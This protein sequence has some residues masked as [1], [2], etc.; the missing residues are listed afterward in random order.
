MRN[1]SKVRIVYP[2][3]VELDTEVEPEPDPPEDEL[4]EPLPLFVEPAIEQL[5]S[6]DEVLQRF[7]VSLSYS[8]SFG[9]L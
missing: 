3:P 5:E 2:P 6:G 7:G 8:S 1:V 9:H 4:V